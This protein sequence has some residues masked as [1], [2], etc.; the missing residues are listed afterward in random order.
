MILFVSKSL[1]FCSIKL[2]GSRTVKPYGLSEYGLQMKEIC[3]KIGF[4][5]KQTKELTLYL[6]WVAAVDWAVNVRV[7]V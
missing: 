6:C 4:P 5:T 7:N 1:D 2:R 3:V